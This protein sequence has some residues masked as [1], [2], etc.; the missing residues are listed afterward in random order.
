MEV[1]AEAP[2]WEDKREALLATG[3]T[4]PAEGTTP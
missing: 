4:E 2:S 3:S 1:A